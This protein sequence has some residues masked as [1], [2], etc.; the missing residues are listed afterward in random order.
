MT[1]I[2]AMTATTAAMTAMA[3]MAEQV[4]RNEG[5][6]ENYP[7]PV[8]GQPVH[9]GLPPFTSFD[10]S[11]TRRPPQRRCPLGPRRIPFAGACTGALDELPPLPGPRDEHRHALHV[12]AVLVA[13]FL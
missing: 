1:F 6:A 13:E 9:L 4:H 10:N 2:G 12:G 5:D 7:D 3:A 8:L 11:L